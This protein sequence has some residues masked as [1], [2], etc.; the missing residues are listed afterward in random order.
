MST[1]NVPRRGEIWYVDL[2][3]RTQ[4]LVLVVSANA[5]ERL[6]VRLV[7]R[8]RPWEDRFN[9]LVW[10]QRLDSTWPTQLSAPHAVDVLQI[11]SMYTVFKSLLAEHRQRK[12]MRSQRRLRWWSI[13]CRQL[14]MS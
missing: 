5:F 12:W 3:D 4:T 14:R 13:M 9:D 10:M 1:A 2:G 6:P 7:A 11:V 8:L